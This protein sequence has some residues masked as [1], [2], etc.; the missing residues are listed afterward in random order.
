LAHVSWKSP[1]TAQGAQISGYQV[2]VDGKQYGAMLQ[3]GVKSIRIKVFYI[4][5]NIA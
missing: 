4:S 5:Q 1:Q 2:L 3:A